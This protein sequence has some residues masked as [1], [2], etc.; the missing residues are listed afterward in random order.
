[1]VPSVQVRELAGFNRE[2]KLRSI[3]TKAVGTLNQG[4]S[5]NIMTNDVEPLFGVLLEIALGLE[6]TPFPAFHLNVTDLGDLK[7]LVQNMSSGV[8]VR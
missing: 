2:H 3:S 6:D 1:M 7:T 4:V 8:D 5:Q